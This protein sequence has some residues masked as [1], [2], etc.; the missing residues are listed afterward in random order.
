MSYFNANVAH[1]IASTVSNHQET[2]YSANK[3]QYVQEFIIPD[4]MLKIQ[5]NS[6][7]GLFS[8]SKSIKN[9]QKV[10]ECLKQVLEEL[11]YKVDYSLD[12]VITISW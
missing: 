7:R 3:K 10:Q 5:K 6:K 4:L 11:G 8:F 9:C 2:V 12:S 1:N